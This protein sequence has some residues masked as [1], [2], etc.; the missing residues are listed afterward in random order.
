[1]QLTLALRE[2]KQ[3]CRTDDGFGGHRR[4]AQALAQKVAR[5]AQPDDDTLR[6]A[7]AVLRKGGL[8][9]VM[10]NTFDA[11]LARWLKRA[12]ALGMV[13]ETTSGYPFH[14]RAWEAVHQF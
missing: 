10:W 6:T 14:K 11:R 13:R 3:P 9:T 8:V 12:V 1:M 5:H 2:P 7:V 4:A